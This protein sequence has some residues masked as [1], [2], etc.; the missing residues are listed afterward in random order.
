MKKQKDF[1]DTIVDDGISAAREQFN[2]AAAQDHL[3]NRLTDD[4]APLHSI[5]Q[6]AQMFV[7]EYGDV[8]RYIPEMNSWRV[9]DGA[10]WAN[11]TSLKTFSMARRICKREA[12]VANEGRLQRTIASPTTWNDV[13]RAVRPDLA[14]PADQWDRDLYLLNTPAGTVDLRTGDMKEHDPH[15]YITKVTS[16]S[17]KAG[18]CSIWQG[19]LKLV[20]GG[21]EELIAY[22]QR[23]GGYCLTGYTKEKQFCFAWGTGDNG[24]SMTFN[25]WQKITGDYAQMA[26]IETFTVTKNDQHPTGLAALCGARLV[27]VSE[28]EA[29][30]TLRESTIKQLTGGDTMTARF[31]RQ[32]EFTYLP[33]LKLIGFGNHKP[34]LRSV[35]EAM[36]SRIHFL[37][38]TVTIT[39]KDKDFREKLAAEEGAILS[40]MIAGAVIWFKEGLNPPQAVLDATDKYLLEQDKFGMFIEDCGLDFS[41]ANAFTPTKHLLQAQNLWGEQHNEWKMREPELIEA[42]ESEGC[43]YGR[44]RLTDGKQCRGFYGVLMPVA[45]TLPKSSTWYER[46]QQKTLERLH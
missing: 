11:D 39:N 1:N 36:R 25:T 13:L 42:L 41:D 3:L 21:D 5:E 2:N 43:P 30:K 15:D 32:D 38:F 6:F 34:V 20:L 18:D 40:W 27:L 9:W 10:R 22:L 16:V 35:N 19:H 24:K 31:M 37:P 45:Q 33:Q 12:R 29:G 28:T 44:K 14:R 4:T 46:H 7:A 8:V 26:S 17:P 23:L